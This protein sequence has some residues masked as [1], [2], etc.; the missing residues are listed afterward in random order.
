MAIPSQERKRGGC[1]TILLILMLIAN[2]LT[3][4]TYLL[5]GAAITQVLPNVPQWG[6]FLLG[7]L[8]FAN[9][10]FALA[11]WTWKKWGVYGLAASSLVTFV[12]NVLTLG[13]LAGLFNLLALG[14]EILIL[15][16]LLRPVWNTMESSCLDQWLFSSP[17]RTAFVVIVFLA[18]LSVGGIGAQYVLGLHPLD[19]AAAQ[20]ANVQGKSDMLRGK[21][22]PGIAAYTAAIQSDPQNARYY[23][24]RGNAYDI[25]SVAEKDTGALDQAIADYTRAIAL[26]EVAHS[27]FGLSIPPEQLTALLYDYRGVDYNRKG[28][29]DQAI[30]DFNKAIAVFPTLSF[31]YIHRGVAYREH[32][33][34]DQAI[35]DFN[36]DLTLE[37]TWARD[38]YDRGLAYQGKGENAQAIAD[39]QKYL[40]LAPNA[41]DRD[42]VQQLIDHLK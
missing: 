10:V 19:P 6:I 4:L 33:N 11:I 25:K 30:A 41:S 5:A 8:S 39:F 12:F 24:D 32:G 23:L 40:Q 38:Y 31:P 16:V 27:S 42:T 36:K 26:V 34:F 7:F 1:L 15:V 18:L 29:Y 35:A 3:G 17:Q 21:V 13:L 9:F 20:Q 14:I 22:D 28:N 2:P 37:P